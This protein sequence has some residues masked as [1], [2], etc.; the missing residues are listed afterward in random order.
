MN[1]GERRFG[2]WRAIAGLAHGLM[3]VPGWLG[4][5]QRSAAAGR[6]ERRFMERIARRL[7]ARVD[8]T[9]VAP[10]GAG[11]LFICNH[12]SWLDIAVL[13]GAL[14]TAFIAKADVRQWP[15]IGLL[16]RR[17]GT[18]FI[19]R[20]ERH[21][22]HHQAER[23]SQRLKAGHS[24][25]LFPEGTTSDGIGVLPFRSSL[26]EAAQHAA[27]IQPIAIGYHRGDGSRLGDEHMRAVGWTG[28]EE[29]LPNLRRV[30]GMH[31]AAE[32]RLT[33]FFTPEPG[34]TRKA[35]A[36]RCREA[37]VEAYGEIRGIATTPSP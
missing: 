34:A 28:D 8:V 17:S 27:R 24:M 11:T 1:E 30:T 2:V 5:E 7:V 32:I 33:P 18:L 31:I 29:L 19:E 16:S 9:G 23:I 12:I 13:G 4:T 35:L 21:R 6:H 37:V 3:L 36:D 26:F 25:L 10:G 22:V 20:E 14:D 15:L